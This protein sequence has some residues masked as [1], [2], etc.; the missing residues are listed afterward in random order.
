[1]AVLKIVSIGDIHFGNPRLVAEDLYNKLRKYLYPEVT[2]AH[3]VTINGDL[4]DQLLTVNSSSHICASRFIRDLFTISAR[5]GM[6]I[7]ILHGTYS[8]D[9][10]QLKVFETMM[11]KSTRC[12][13]VNNIYC[14]E[15]SDFN[16]GIS[17]IDKIL[18]VAYLPDNLSCKLSE[19]AVTH[20]TEAITCAGYTD[21]DLLVGHGTFEHTIPPDS[22]HRPP[23]LYTEQQFRKIVPNGI[24]SMGHIH[25]HG[26]HNNI[27]YTGSFDRMAHNEEEDKGYYVFT[28]DLDKNV[29]DSKFVVN[30][31]AVKFI[32]LYPTGEDMSDVVHDFIRLVKTAFGDNPSGH[33][34]VMHPGAEVR[35]LLHKTCN[36]NF[37]NLQY[38]SKAIG[39]PTCAKMEVADIN[40]N[41]FED[42]KPNK[43]NLGDLVYRFLHE[44]NIVGEDKKDEIITATKSLL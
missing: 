7:R 23:C 1:M 5:T 30:E 39:E 21:V 41:I 34:R 24:V 4:Y 11:G 44:K 36:Q 16:N 17:K 27:Y 37:P 26:R 13:V 38:G 42:I 33:V 15:I 22:G 14:E 19:E 12:K 25:K 28:V 29:W 9:R 3:L 8:H 18:R 10:D 32:S 2:D 20:L 40:L 6:Q 31:D 35:A 43:D